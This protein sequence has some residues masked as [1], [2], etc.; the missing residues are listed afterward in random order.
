MG[1]YSDQV[2]TLGNKYEQNQAAQVPT[3]LS[4]GPR[5]SHGGRESPNTARGFSHTGRLCRDD[6]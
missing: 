4:S 5:F 1:S 2:Y 3:S 6:L